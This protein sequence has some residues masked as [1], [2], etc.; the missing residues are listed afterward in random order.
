MLPWGASSFPFERIHVDFTGKV[1]GVYWFIIVDAF[2]K[3][4]EL[5]PLN[6]CTSDSTI[7]CLEDTFSRWGIPRSIVSD[8]GRQLCSHEFKAFC[9]RYGIKHITSSPYHS[10][11]NGQVERIIRT[12]KEKYVKLGQLQNIHQRLAVMLYWY[13][14]TPSTSTQ[15]SPSEVMI[16]RRLRGAIE[17][18]KPSIKNNITDSAD[19]QKHFHDRRKQSRNFETGDLVWTKNELL[20]GFSKGTITKKTGELSYHVDVD[21]ITKRKHAD[22]LKRRFQDS[23]YNVVEKR[24]T[25]ENSIENLDNFENTESLN[26]NSPDM[27]DVQIPRRSSRIRKPPKRFYD[28]YLKEWQQKN[29]LEGED[30]VGIE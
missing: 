16:G 22:H 28:E 15:R 29:L 9:E 12:L 17:N 3:W 24:Q 2:S 27:D 21:G 7:T 6:V 26:D 4:V 19:K 10:R 25:D 11:T 5:Y 30:D 18:L 20:P 1:D 13:R 23:D 14:N 8:N